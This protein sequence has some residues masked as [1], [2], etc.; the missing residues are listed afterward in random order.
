M[1]VALGLVMDDVRLVGVLASFLLIA[2][3]LHES[4]R[5]LLSALAIWVG[6]MVAL[7]VSVNHQL[8]LKLRK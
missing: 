6:L 8:R 2:F 5:P 3:I 4:G 7:A 1:K